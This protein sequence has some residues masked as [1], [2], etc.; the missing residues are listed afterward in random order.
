MHPITLIG[1]GLA[2]YTLAR[3]L[4]KR[5][6]QLPLRLISRDSA[7]FYSKPMLSNALSKGKTAATLVNTPAAAMAEQLNA[8]ILAHC[9]VQ[10]IDPAA[11]SITADGQTLQYSALILALGSDSIRPALAGDGAEDILQVNDLDDFRRFEQRL[12]GGPKRVAILGGG[13]IGC[14]F[15]NDL[16]GAGHQVQVIDRGAAPLGRLVP[17][18]VG[19]ALC[20][21]LVQAGVRWHANDEAIRIDREADGVR[22]GLKQGGAIPAD[23]VLSALGLRPRTALAAAAGLRAERGIV[24]DGYLQ[25]S[26]QD[27][28]ALGDCAEVDGQVLPFVLPIMHGARALAATLTGMPSVV[29][30]PLMPVAVKTPAYPIVV[31]P[32]VPGATGAWRIKPQSDGVQAEFRDGGGGLR[33]FVLGGE[34]LAL[35]NGLLKE[36]AVE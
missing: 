23:V 20:Q 16:V 19:E 3:E 10:A 29:Q 7:D 22:I 9:P 2:A 35:K 34:A 24:V 4:R 21:A 25:S 32:P 33:G 8:E 1:S 26:A 14:E 5:D 27:V 30:Y 11:H 12:A 17:Q 31:L 15:A 18:A 13:L 28:Y 6:A 36:M